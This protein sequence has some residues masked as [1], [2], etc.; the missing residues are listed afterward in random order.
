MALIATILLAAI[1]YRYLE[2]PFLRLKDRFTL[3]R[4]RPIT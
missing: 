4:S 2:S 1:S 3:V